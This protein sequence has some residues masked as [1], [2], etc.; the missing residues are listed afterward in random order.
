MGTENACILFNTTETPLIIDSTGGVVDF[1]LKF[2]KQQNPNQECQL[3]KVSFFTELVG[4][5]N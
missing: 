4:F 2:H 5:I 1:L 3:L